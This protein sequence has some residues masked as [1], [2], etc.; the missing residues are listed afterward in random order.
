MASYRE[1]APYIGNHYAKHLGFVATCRIRLEYPQR[2]RVFG[3][4]RMNAWALQHNIDVRN[5]YNN[6]AGVHEQY[7]WFASTADATHYALKHSH[8]HA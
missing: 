1:F 4:S 3:P 7:V 6:E 5:E 2:V 8:E